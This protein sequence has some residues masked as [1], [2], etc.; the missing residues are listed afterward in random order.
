M[1]ELDISE[2]EKVEIQDL[3]DDLHEEISDRYEPS[4]N[5]NRKLKKVA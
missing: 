3:I 5:F 2:E 4:K 1:L